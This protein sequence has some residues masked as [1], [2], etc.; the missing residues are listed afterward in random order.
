MVFGNSIETELMEL[1]LHEQMKTNG[2][3][4]FGGGSSVYRMKKNVVFGK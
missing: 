4:V 3:K 2:G 1:D